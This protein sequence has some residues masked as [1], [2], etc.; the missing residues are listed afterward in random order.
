M[1][2]C[3]CVALI[4]VS[5]VSGGLAM[6]LFTWT[7]WE[8]EGKLRELPED[9]QQQWYDGTYKPEQRSSGARE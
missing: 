5:V 4:A 1:L 8:V 9:L 3:V 7:K 6:L 2:T